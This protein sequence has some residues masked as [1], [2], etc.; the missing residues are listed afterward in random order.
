MTDDGKKIIAFLVEG[1]SDEAAIGSVMK[2]YFADELVQFVV[3]RGDI[4]TRDYVSADNIIRKI[5]E[6]IRELKEKYRYKTSDFM[7]II[8]ISDTDGVF[9][10]DERVQ[11]ADV[12][13]IK[14]YE[15]HVETG[16]PESIVE[17]NHKKA[18]IL[19]KL[20]RTGKIGRI[21]YRIYYNSC[22]LEHVLFN[23]RKHF[24]AEEKEEMSDAFAEKYEEKPEEFLAFLSEHKV[25]VP[26]TYQETWKYIEQECHSLQRYTNMHQIFH[27]RP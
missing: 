4:T 8:H 1:A 19:F 7:G 13:A 16:L 10:E 5:N 17:R 23:E 20:S 18:E 22:N 27:G 2:G 12:E 6:R 9:I 26:G 25:A 15:D 3:M 14:Y 21:P 24:T 11:Y